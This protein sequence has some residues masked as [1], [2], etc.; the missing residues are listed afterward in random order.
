MQVNRWKEPYQPNPAML[1][2]ILSNEGLAV[3]QWCDSAG[4]MRA[5]HK[6]DKDQT[7]WIVSGSLEIRLSKT[8]ETYLL[9]TGDRG[10]IEAETYYSLSVIGEEPVLYLVGE[11]V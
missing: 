1:R 7:H 9:E 2:F 11:K 10:F 4:S 3:Y 8:G 6:H 5:T